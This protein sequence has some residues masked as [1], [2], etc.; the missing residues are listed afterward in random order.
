MI[1]LFSL[2]FNFT[3]FPFVYFVTKWFV[4]LILK[5]RI[6]VS[7]N[8]K[9]SKREN[10]FSFSLENLDSSICF[11][12]IPKGIF[13][14]FFV[15]CFSVR[16]FSKI[17]LVCLVFMGRICLLLNWFYGQKWNY[18]FHK[19]FSWIFIFICEI[20]FYQ[21]VEFAVKYIEKQRIKCLLLTI[22]NGMKKGLVYFWFW[23]F[24][25]I[26]FIFLNW[27]KFFLFLFF[28]YFYQKKYY[29]I[30]CI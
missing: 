1:S 18:G 11:F 30:N 20:C 14:Y 3:L 4:W 16:K 10:C 27:L 26:F 5:Q 7:F 24:L 25:K 12:W 6:S 9:F 19:H 28:D 8:R 13:L 2:L 17:E 23:N 15:F 22:L 21:N 29:D